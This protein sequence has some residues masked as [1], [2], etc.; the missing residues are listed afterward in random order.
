MDIGVMVNK[1]VLMCVGCGAMVCGVL[2]W[3]CIE[4][5]DWLCFSNML[6]VKDYEMV[7]CD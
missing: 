2:R 3:L 4:D 1:I 5:E 7:G 6:E